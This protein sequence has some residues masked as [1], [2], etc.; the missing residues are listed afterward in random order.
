MLASIHC[1]WGGGAFDVEMIVL[2]GAA[3]IQ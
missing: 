1:K 3:T 2:T